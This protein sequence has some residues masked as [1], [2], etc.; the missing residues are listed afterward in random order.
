MM[1]VGD[2]CSK[3]EEA[4]RFYM[5]LFSNSEVRTLKRYGAGE[6]GGPEGALKLY[7]TGKQSKYD[8]KRA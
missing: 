4:M 7:G 3:A 8:R 5:S 6:Q 2:Q 1:F